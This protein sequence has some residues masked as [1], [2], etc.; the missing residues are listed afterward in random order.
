MRDW[1]RKTSWK[2]VDKTEF[3]QKLRRAH[4]DNRA[5][6]VRIQGVHLAEAGQHKAAVELF[7]RVLAEF[8]DPF[9][10]G[11]A[12]SGLG[13]SLLVLREYERALDALRRCVRSERENSG[14]RNNASLEFAFTVACLDA[15][16]LFQE[17]RQVLRDDEELEMF[18]LFPLDSFKLHAARAILTRSR[19][20]A[21][22]EAAA[23]LGEAERADS[24]WRRHAKLGLVGDAF[25]ALR[26][27]LLAM[28]RN[29]TPRK[30][31]LRSGAR[32]SGQR[33]R[34]GGRGAED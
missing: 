33:R 22:E 25:P 27:R 8:P 15:R 1:F 4:R 13:Q 24:G 29:A 31:K 19:R 28:A 11:S 32:G 26:T 9:E 6:Y 10:V 21:A 5:Q 18:V 34:A 12:L 7:E 23:A 14:P 16:K 3:E 20:I 17:A 30:A 2:Q